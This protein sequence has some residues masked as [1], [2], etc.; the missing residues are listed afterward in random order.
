M[1]V[2]QSGT[3]DTTASTTLAFTFQNQSGQ[4]IT[5]NTYALAFEQIGKPIITAGGGS[6]SGGGSSTNAWVPLPTAGGGWHLAGT[7]TNL[8]P[9][10]NTTNGIPVRVWDPDTEWTLRNTF[11]IPPTLPSTPTY[12]SFISQWRPVAG[13][14]A[15][16]NIVV[17]LCAMQAGDSDAFGAEVLVTNTVSSQAW[18][19]F[20][21]T[22][23]ITN[24]LRGSSVTIKV[25]AKTTGTATNNYQ[26]ILQGVTV[27]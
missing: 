23:P 11:T 16:Q 13:N 12:I 26:A 15:S 8:F 1:P 18:I 14:S 17:G 22:V 25:A 27:W 19:N 3:L 6:S 21:N 24:F 10:P 5:L 2:T 9:T 4:E 20:T 7:Q